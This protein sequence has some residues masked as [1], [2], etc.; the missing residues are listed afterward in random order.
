MST[1]SEEMQAVYV[2]EG[3]IDDMQGGENSN[4]RRAMPFKEP[5]EMGLQRWACERERERERERES[6][7]ARARARAR[8]IP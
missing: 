6:A 7:R 2:I 1:E 3:S 4:V 5:R 8:S